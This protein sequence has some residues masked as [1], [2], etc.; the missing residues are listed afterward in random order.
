MLRPF[1]SDIFKCAFAAHLKPQQA[2]L[3]PDAGIT[4][5]E[6]PSLHSNIP[7]VADFGFAFKLPLC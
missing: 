4:R 3:R 7:A 2:T 5:S 1:A 6:I